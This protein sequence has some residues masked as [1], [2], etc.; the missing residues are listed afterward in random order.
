MADAATGAIERTV[1]LAYYV[2]RRATFTLSQATLDVPDYGPA[3]R[4]GDD[5][6]DLGSRSGEALRKMFSRDL[7]AIEKRFGIT[8]EFD[9]EENVYR[10]CPPYFTKG[11]RMALLSAMALVEV[12]GIDD[13]ADSLERLGRA[14]DESGRRVVVTVHEH[15]VALRRAMAAGHPV[16]FRYHGTDRVLEAWLIG[17]WRNHWYVIG[18]ERA[19]GERRVFRLDRI[20]RGDGPPIHEL[21]EQYV[22][23][24]DVTPRDGLRLDP[25]DW[26]RDPPLTVTIDVHPDH[27]DR[28]RNELGGAVVAPD[29]IPGDDWVR[30]S[31]LV[32]DYESTRDRILRMGTHARVQGPEEFVARVRDWLDAIIGNP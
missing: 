22:I 25:N 30:V 10:V 12:A 21:D 1:R 15:V 28:F 4:D 18:H 27:A 26:G 11:E 3:D 13:D 5:R 2:S 9:S 31:L 14:V 17:Q 8:T 16:T 7:A 20:E 23:P 32:R 19:S 6:I 29:G 24:D